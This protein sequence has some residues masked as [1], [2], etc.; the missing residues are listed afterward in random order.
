M[1]CD[2]TSFSNFIDFINLFWFQV[3]SFRASDRGCIGAFKMHL[4]LE[5]RFSTKK[6]NL[7]S[8]QGALPLVSWLKYILVKICIF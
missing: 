2:I 1:A 6:K 8:S 7:E 4:N 3:I 5:I